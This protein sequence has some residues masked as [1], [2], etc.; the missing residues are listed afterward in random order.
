MNLLGFLLLLFTLFLYKWDIVSQG[1]DG[2]VL[3]DSTSSNTAEKDSLANNPS[4]CGFSVIDNAK[5]IL[6]KLCPGVVSCDDIVAFA[7]RDGFLI[8]I[9]FF[10][11]G[12]KRIHLANNPTSLRIQ[13]ASQLEEKASQT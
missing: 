5:T 13:F 3:I 6:E 12:W 4:L 7:A 2:S 10:N 11:T 9:N 1:C 8:D